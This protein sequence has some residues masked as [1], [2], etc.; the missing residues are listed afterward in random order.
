MKPSDHI[1][2]LIKSLS[3]TEKGYF[4]KFAQRHGIKANSNYLQLFKAIEAQDEYDEKL[5][6]KKFN[7]SQ[8][9][10][11][12]HVYKNYLY[13]L[14]LRALHNYYTGNT[15]TA[16]IS[17]LIHYS[18][19]LKERG[20]FIQAKK[21]LEQAKEIAEKYEKWELLL[22]VLK[23]LWD[24]FTDAEEFNKESEAD[25]RKL[26]DEKKK[27]LSKLQ[28]ANEHY[29]YS[30]LFRIQ[31]RTKGIYNI[32]RDFDLY[33]NKLKLPVVDE[34]A[35]N[36]FE[37]E[38]VYY[39]SC[40]LYYDAQSDFVK[41]L[42]Y[43][44]KILALF[45][46][47]PYQVDENLQF[48]IHCLFA[49]SAKAENCNDEKSYQYAVA[50]LD[51]LHK[52]LADTDRFVPVSLWLKI[53]FYE[54]K[55]FYSYR[56]RMFREIKALDEEVRKIKLI[57]E[58]EK[59]SITRGQQFLTSRKELMTLYFGTLL[60]EGGYYT[61]SIYWLNMLAATKGDVA[62]SGPR[63]FAKLVLT[64]AYFDLKKWDLF[65][66]TALH[67]MRIISKAPAQYPF[68]KN[69]INNLT[70]LSKANSTEEKDK[71]Y[72]RMEEDITKYSTLKKHNQSFRYFD[73]EDWIEGK[74]KKKPM[75]EVLT[76]R[77]YGRNSK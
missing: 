20:L 70:K 48:Y 29:L 6:D 68:E 28:L 76:A 33:N 69:F 18:E 53:S 75:W 30:S 58:V 63:F 65:S 25:V 37:L 41:S 2:F 44:K 22:D 17:E 49:T 67:F 9:S 43:L 8:L 27:V 61:E 24:M 55:I 38:R 64:I 40:S 56:K 51:K 11:Q 16:K 62:K 77:P 39:W 72:H 59:Y 45:N 52:T 74:L 73:F 66:N 4:N 36:S 7:N 32:P 19:I 15:S 46:K 31:K 47:H 54:T 5:L 14:I 35:L 50:E 13:K 71:L 12:I 10:G 57:E 26:Y 1:F 60:L 21:V 42:E 3:K 34:K 23:R